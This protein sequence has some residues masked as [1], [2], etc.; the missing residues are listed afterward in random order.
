MQDTTTL[1]HS[2]TEMQDGADMFRYVGQAVEL[3]RNTFGAEY[4]EP[5]EPDWRL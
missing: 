4:E 1:T 3:M 5:D 2:H